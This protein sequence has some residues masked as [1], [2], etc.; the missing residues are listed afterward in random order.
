MKLQ[1]II[2][3]AALVL[4]SISAASAGQPQQRG[5]WDG[6]GLS[7]SGMAQGTVAARGTTVAGKT[8]VAGQGAQVLYVE[9]PAN[10]LST[11]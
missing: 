11:K 7:V 1:Q 9:L 2:A 4:L 8:A 6:N 3:S 5:G 10:R